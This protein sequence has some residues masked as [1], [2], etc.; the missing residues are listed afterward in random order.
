MFNPD[1][2]GNNAGLDQKSNNISSGQTAAQEFASRKE[3]RIYKEDSITQLFKFMKECGGIADRLID[4][5]EEKYNDPNFEEEISNY[6]DDL[7]KFVEKWNEIH[8]TL[9]LA[10]N[11]IDDR[12]KYGDYEKII[13][14]FLIEVGETK[15]D[16]ARILGYCSKYASIGIERSDEVTEYRKYLR[17]CPKCKEDIAHFM[18]KQIQLYK[19]SKELTI[20]TPIKGY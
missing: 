9:T 10:R 2:K 3:V 15:A 5:V 8:A 6:F 17:N 7:P 14:Q 4:A 1:E 12:N 20:D 19:S 16:I 11:E 13:A 18:D